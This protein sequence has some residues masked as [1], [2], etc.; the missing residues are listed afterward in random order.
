MT[1]KF[2]IENELLLSDTTMVEFADGC[3]DAGSFVPGI[4]EVDEVVPCPACDGEHRIAHAFPLEVVHNAEITTVEAE[5]EP[6]S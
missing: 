4:H 5:D 3:S 6:G 2:R 1:E